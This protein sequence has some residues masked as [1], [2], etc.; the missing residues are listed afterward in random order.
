MKNWYKI[1]ISTTA[2]AFCAAYLL[3]QAPAQSDAEKAKAA[4]KAQDIARAFELNA[5]TFTLLDRQG[6][7]L[8][9]VG[10]RGMYGAVVFSPDAKRIALSKADL[11]KET[12]DIFVMDLAN[13]NTIQLTHGQWRENIFAPVWSPDGSQLAY[14]ALRGG[15]FGIYRIASD[16]KGQEE[17]LYKLP[18]V[19]NV[20][21]W[22]RDG[23]FLSLSWGDLGGSVLSALPVTG[24][25]DRK[26]IEYFKSPKQVGGWR[27]S[28]DG[29]MVAYISNETGKN[30][31]YIRRFDPGAGAT[32]PA[33]PWQISDQG[34][35]GGG[36]WRGDGK[37]FYYLSADRSIMTVDVASSP[38]VAFGK[39]KIMY[40]IPDNLGVGAG[41]I[42]RTG[43]LMVMAIPPPRLQQLTVYD[44]TGKVVRTAGE[45]TVN[46]V[47][48]HFSPDGS[49]LT[50]MRQD[51]KTSDT[52]IW[53]YDLE[54][55]KEYNLSR[56]NWPENA[57][58][59]SRDGK[60]V[61]YASTRDNYSSI[62]QRNWDGT[63]EEQMLF[64]YTPGA[65]MVL[66]DTTPDEK[67]AAFYT[68]V[69]VLAPI[70]SGTDPLARKGIDWLRDEFTVLGG[71][72][73]PD[74]RYVA[75]AAD[76]DDP[77]ALDLYVRP[78]DESKAESHADPPPAVQITKGGIASGMVAWRQDGKALYYMTR[79][80]EV[81]EMDVTTT[82]AFK[83]GTPK[84]LFKLPSQPM[85]N[86]SQWDNVT[87]DGQRFVFTMMVR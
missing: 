67:Y 22:S 52:D 15:L 79:D 12:Q 46:V 75:Y 58:I 70:K 42:S 40:H 51:P 45:P 48:P 73:S 39:P 86:P 2:A 13:G 78:F 17:L 59:W 68:G 14:T 37:E 6:K 1:A 19:V 3:A 27:I 61:M 4:R 34:S 57:P 71:K 82:P 16:G 56:D 65:G 50:F 66:T 5:R 20:T 55:G 87:R 69:L 36:F 30:E 63:G 41:D 49:K 43:D 53:T 64:R 62:Y 47:Q 81:M 26:P 38:A 84:L 11:D 29:R 9:T 18:G 54:T 31:M 44:R 60:R 74:G 76:V 77:M 21:D 7:E 80:W 85:G 83:A 25:A 28:P 10:P 8:K 24:G 72:F 32:D 33:G 35:L 23:R